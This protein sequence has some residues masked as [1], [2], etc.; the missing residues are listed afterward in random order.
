MIAGRDPFM[1]AARITR[2]GK[3]APK[4][5]AETLIGGIIC[6]AVGCFLVLAGLLVK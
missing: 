5:T 2:S 3:N 1:A 6:L 4:P